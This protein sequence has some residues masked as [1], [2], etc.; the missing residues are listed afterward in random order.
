MRACTTRHPFTS[1]A[2]WPRMQAGCMWAGCVWAGCMRAGCMFTC[3]P[4]L[5]PYM[6]LHAYMQGQLRDHAPHHPVVASVRTALRS[7]ARQPLLSGGGGSSSQAT[8]IPGRPMIQ[9]QSSAAPAPGA[10][11]STAMY[12]GPLGYLATALHRVSSGS[13]EL[14]QLLDIFCAPA[15][16][17][18][19]AQPR[20]HTGGP[21]RQ[22][23]AAAARPRQHAQVA[24]SRRRTGSQAVAAG[25]RRSSL[26]ATAAPSSCY[27][28]QGEDYQDTVA[29]ADGS[30][31]SRYSLQGEG[32][33]GTAAAADRSG[34]SSYGGR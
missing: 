8:S 7:S 3:L 14:Q 34:S 15:A 4:A 1:M 18:R 29:A 10:P 28:L 2:S 5:P 13:Q 32:Y 17:A 20:Q 21:S 6:P 33:Q 19:P 31:S 25:R 22:P 27:S 30:G 12:S 11:A 23:A 26:P 9:Q 16:A 24:P